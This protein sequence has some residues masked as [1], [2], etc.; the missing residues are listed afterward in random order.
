MLTEWVTVCIVSLYSCIVVHG[1]KITVVIICCS[2]PVCLSALEL[3]CT[4]LSCPL[5]QNFSS[6][7]NLPHHEC[8]TISSS[9]YS[10][11][12]VSSSTGITDPIVLHW[13]CSSVIIYI[14]HYHGCMYLMCV[15]ILSYFCSSSSSGH[16]QESPLPHEPG[17]A[18][19][20]VVRGGF[21]CQ[22]CLLWVWSWVSVKRLETI[23]IVHYK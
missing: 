15:S 14:A 5:I 18:Q 19:G 21:P 13:P 17:P 2:I 20:F 4:K 7:L 22:S 3:Q 6:S 11:S 12:R 9:V 23:L 1:S 8:Q 10:F 16:Q